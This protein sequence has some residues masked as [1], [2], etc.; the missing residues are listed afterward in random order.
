LLIEHRQKLT[1][2]VNGV[3]YTIWNPAQD[4]L[5]PERYDSE[6]VLQKKQFSK[7]ELQKRFELPLEPNTPVLG[8]VA[9][10]VSQ[11]GL[12]LV[13]GAA[14][15]ILDL[16][17]QMIFLGEGDREFHDQLQSFREQ[18]PNQVGVY[19]GFNETLAHLV[20]AGSDLFLMPS[21]FEPSG[22]NQLYSLKYGTPPIVRATGGLA[23]TIVNSTEENMHAGIAT[24]FTFGDY[25][26]H[27]LYETTKWAIHLYKNRPADFHKI[28][29]TAMV[30]DWS[31]NRSAAAYEAMY[32]RV[33]A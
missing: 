4:I 24:G 11:K 2:I 27:A 10:L 21:R 23:D 18:H 12:D 3:D 7:H 32:R 31:W 20:E 26:A 15:G 28:I 29:H 1:G 14:K 30:Q 8:M 13:L 16:G 33:L 5:L 17:C 6:T 19:L 22:L 25:S 9:R